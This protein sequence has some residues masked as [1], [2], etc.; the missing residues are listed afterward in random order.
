L[1]EGKDDLRE[2]GHVNA[3]ALEIIID[4]DLPMR[5]EAVCVR[6]KAKAPRDVHLSQNIN[7]T[8]LHE[9]IRRRCLE[10]SLHL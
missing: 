7:S 5:R 4:P 8:R 3:P 2:F 9:L 10:F 1:S 6:A